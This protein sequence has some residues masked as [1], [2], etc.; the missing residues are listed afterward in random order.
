MFKCKICEEEF[1]HDGDAMMHIS[2]GHGLIEDTEHPNGLTKEDFPP[3]LHGLIDAID[4][5][6]KGKY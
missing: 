6:K 2:W 3:E 5:Q 4:K 1:E